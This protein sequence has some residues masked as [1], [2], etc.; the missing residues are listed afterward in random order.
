MKRPRRPGTKILR[1]KPEAKPA[2][3]ESHS[4]EGAAS[5]LQ[6]LQQMETRR[7]LDARMADPRLPDDGKPL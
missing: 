6:I 2:W 7:G 3:S 5:A 4:G 1:A